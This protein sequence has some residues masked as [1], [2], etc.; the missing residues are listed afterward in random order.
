MHLNFLRLNAAGS[1]GLDASY[2]GG[3]EDEIIRAFVL[4]PSGDVYIAGETESD[5]FPTTPGAAQ[6][7]SGNAGTS[8]DADAFIEHIEQLCREL[9]V[10]R[11]LSQVGVRPEQLNDLVQG[12]RGNSMNGNP[13][14]LSD[15]ELRAILEECL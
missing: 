4:A 1:A 12:S 8:S 2:V 11:N 3:S 5:D 13:R 9:N 10:P 14:Q 7:A 15:A 6:T